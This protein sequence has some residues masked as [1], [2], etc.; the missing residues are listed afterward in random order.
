MFFP[1]YRS[2]VFK[3][4]AG[5]SKH[6]KIKIALLHA[7]PRVN[8]NLFAVFI[9]WRK[10]QATNLVA[11]QLRLQLDTIHAALSWGHAGSSRLQAAKVWHIAQMH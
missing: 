3:S 9:T 10:L 11:G 4:L 5:R 8:I 7:A 1:H 2:S 6:D